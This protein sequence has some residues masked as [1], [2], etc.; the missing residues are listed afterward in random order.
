MA[1]PKTPPSNPPDAKDEFFFAQFREFAKEFADESDRAAVILGA[2]RMDVALYDLLTARLLPSPTSTDELFDG[3]AP[4]GSFSAKI[5]MAYRLGL[6][7]AAFARALHILRKIRNAFAHEVAGCTLAT[8][9]HSNRVRELVAPFHSWSSFETFKKN[10]LPSVE[11]PSADFRA[12]LGVMIVRLAATADFTKTVGSD[13][14]LKL[15][16]GD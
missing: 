9:S 3:E 14:A 16:P 6:I 7:E 13:R 4:L 1:E 5:N 10:L 12:A 15:L 11:G 8:G 2:A